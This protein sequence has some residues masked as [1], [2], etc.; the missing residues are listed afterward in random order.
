MSENNRD[1]AVGHG[2]LPVRR[3]FKK[4]QSSN[5]RGP[6]REAGT[7]TGRLCSE[8]L[9]GQCRCTSGVGPTPPPIAQRP[10]FSRSYN[11]SPAIWS[12]LARG[13]ARIGFRKT[14]SSPILPSLR[15]ATVLIPPP[16]S[17][18]GVLPGRR[19]AP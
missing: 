10:H 16:S 14:P 18:S 17:A 1:Y 13:R 8:P 11:F 19:R 5:P 6:R 2:K 12:R 4:G 9:V 3:R 7:Y 15:V